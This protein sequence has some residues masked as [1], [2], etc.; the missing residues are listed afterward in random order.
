MSRLKKK[1]RKANPMDM[2]LS[3][4]MLEQTA[5]DKPLSPHCE[6]PCPVTGSDSRVLVCLR[7]PFI[8]GTAISF[9]KYR[10]LVA[11]PPKTLH[12]GKK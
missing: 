7:L 4:E 1:K 9:S 3:V 5:D 10:L 2:V 11:L 6:C 12:T 8:P